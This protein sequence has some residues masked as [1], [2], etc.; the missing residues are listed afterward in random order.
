MVRFTFMECKRFRNSD[1]KSPVTGSQY[2]NRESQDVSTASNIRYNVPFKAKRLRNRLI[3][4]PLT[5][6]NE[7]Q[8]QH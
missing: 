6:Q 3:I 2:T 1:C 4:N 7:T 5:K 8:A